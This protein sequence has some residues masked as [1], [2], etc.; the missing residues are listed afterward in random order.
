[1]T[2]KTV[3]DFEAQDYDRTRFVDDIGRH[4]DYMHKKILWDFIGCHQKGQL[5]L[6]AGIGTGRLASWLAKRGHSIIGIDV[7]IEMMQK[8]REK[9]QKMNLDVVF[10]RADISYLPFKQGVFDACYT[11]NVLDHLTLSGTGGFF[12]ESRYVTKPDGFLVFNFSNL[13][14][15]Y[16]PIALL[17]NSKK[18][19]LFKREK[20][21]SVWSTLKEIKQLLFAANFNSIKLKGVMVAS[22]IPFIGKASKVIPVI[23]FAFEDSRF[24]NFC[25]SIFI[26]ALAAAES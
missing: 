21:F 4:L 3:Y 25:G 23:D 8:A 17:V 15:I 5:L 1:M 18:Q 24:K 12:K 10:V 2:K 19:A 13:Q 14:S 20:I 6:E 22:F 7:S 26:K 11:I 16:L 9:K